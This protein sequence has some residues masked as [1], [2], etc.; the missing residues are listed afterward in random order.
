MN[1]SLNAAQGLRLTKDP[2]CPFIASVDPYERVAIVDWG[3]SVGMRSWEQIKD[4]FGYEIVITPEEAEMIERGRHA[5]K[6]KE[7]AEA[8]KFAIDKWLMQEK[9]R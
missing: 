3:M 5:L 4:E 1:V 7:A 2:L 6:V 9:R 8:L